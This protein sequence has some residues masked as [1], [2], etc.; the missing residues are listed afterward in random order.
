MTN[1]RQEDEDKLRLPERYVWSDNTGYG[2]G[3]IHLDVPSASDIPVFDYTQLVSAKDADLAR[4]REALTSWGYF[5]IVNHGIEVSMIK[6]LRHLSQEFFDLPKEEKQKYS[7]SSEGFEGYGS[8]H[9]LFEN[10]TL[11]W[12]DRLY[13]IVLP[14]DQR[15]LEYWPINPK[16]FRDAL[17]E[18]SDRVWQIQEQLLKAMARSLSLHEDRFVEQFGEH[19][20]MHARL[21]VY[22]PCSWPEQVLGFK[23]HSDSSGLTILLQDNDIEGLQVFK[24]NRWFQVPTLPHALLVNVGDQIEIMSNEVFKSPVHKVVTNTNK[25]RRTLVMFCIPDPAQEIEP[26]EELICDEQPR[27]FKNIRDYYPTFFPYYQQGKRAIDAVR[28]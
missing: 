3:P 20:E 5:Q 23:P 9:V 21:N 12:N 13:L 11:D 15:K 22:R 4:L 27:L 2:Y 26:A 17:S 18:Y 25:E 19:P 6:K 7:I 24:D 1:P 8:D 10:Q 16:S 28:I 14:K